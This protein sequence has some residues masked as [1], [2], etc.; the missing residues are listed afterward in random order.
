MKGTQ[1]EH[2]THALIHEFRWSLEKTQ[3]A[4]ECLLNSYERLSLVHTIYYGINV[5]SKT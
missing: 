2:T 5:T 1:D 4:F 3:K